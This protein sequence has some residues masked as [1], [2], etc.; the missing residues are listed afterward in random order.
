MKVENKFSIK[1][2]ESNKAM[3]P[4]FKKLLVRKKALYM[5]Q[6]NNTHQKVKAN[7]FL[8]LL[9]KHSEIRT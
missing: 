5:P 7:N 2:I 9:K 8:Y 1:K 6:T 4:K 3:S